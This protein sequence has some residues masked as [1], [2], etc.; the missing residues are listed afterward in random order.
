MTMTALKLPEQ[1][2]G[3]DPNT[4][5]WIYQSSRPFTTEESIEI[6]MQLQAFAKTWTAHNQ[7]LQAAGFL[8]FNRVIVLMV[9]ESHTSASGC[10]ID[11]STHFIQSLEKKYGV[12]LFN[13]ML[14]YYQVNGEWEQTNLR[15]LRELVSQSKVSDQT[16]VINPLVQNKSAFDS[17]FITSAAEC[18]IADFL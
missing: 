9:D 14:V 2:V 5:V 16:T 7:Q 11:T 3:M 18:W 10:S 15:D 1:I 8:Q 12:E 4:R 6:D 17:G 13:R